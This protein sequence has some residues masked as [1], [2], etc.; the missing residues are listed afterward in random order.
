MM[1]TVKWICLCI[2]KRNI[3]PCGQVRDMYGGEAG[4]RFECRFTDAC[5]G[6]RD[7]DGGKSIAF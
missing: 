5:Y 4:A 2:G 1:G 6:G 7:V 3:A